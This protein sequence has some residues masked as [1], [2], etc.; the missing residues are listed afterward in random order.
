MH[1]FINQYLNI[2]I[3]IL[4]CINI[5]TVY[6]CS[7]KLYIYILSDFSIEKLT[8]KMQ[9]IQIGL[10]THIFYSLNGNIL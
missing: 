2:V 8:K 9:F 3:R 7:K 5:N 6:L 10:T 4:E 1:K